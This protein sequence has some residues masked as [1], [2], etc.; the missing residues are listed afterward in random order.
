MPQNIMPPNALNS[1][2]KNAVLANIT[3]I[4]FWGFSFISIKIAVPVFPPM[5][6]GAVRFAIAIVLLFIMYRISPG[7][8]FYPGDLPYLIASGFA[9]VTFYFFCENNGVALV[10][11]SEASIII[12]SIPVLTMTCEWLAA[13]L[14]RTGPVRLGWQRWLGVFIS[15]AGVILVARV[16]FVLSGSMAGYVFMGGAALCWV[17]YGFLTKPLFSRGRSRIYIVFWQNFFG[18]LGFL[19]FTIGE[20]KNWGTP[21]LPVL[22]HVLFLAVCCSA[23]GYW[24]YVQALEVLGVS[25]S[26]VFINLTPVVTGIAGFFILGD[27]L[28]PL[29]WIGAVLVLMGVYLTVLPERRGR[30][31]R[32]KWKGGH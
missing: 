2:R 22:F 17:A 25:V 12:A 24:L 8:K 15:M 31:F 9:G 20:Y 21:N 18:L 7:E 5:T 23:L 30:P 19:P 6:L 26:S 29:Q 11:A 3:C 14:R 1:R 28:S 4:L 13:K 32:T 27:R 10:T 16:S